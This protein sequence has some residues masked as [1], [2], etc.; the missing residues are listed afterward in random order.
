VFCLIVGGDGCYDLRFGF[1]LECQAPFFCVL[2][3]NDPL[4]YSGFR[5]LPR[6]GTFSLVSTNDGNSLLKNSDFYNS[7]ELSENILETKK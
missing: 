1:L 6:A 7:Y 3:L 5:F 2:H 4:P